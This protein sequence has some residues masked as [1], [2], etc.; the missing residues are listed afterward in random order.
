MPRPRLHAPEQVLDAVTALTAESGPAAVTIRAVAAASGVSN[1][2]IYHTFGSRTGLLAAA[3]LRAAGAFLARQRELVA[4]AGAPVEQVIAAADAPVV[5]AAE[6]PAAGALL[7]RLRPD[8]LTGADLPAEPA[9]AVAALRTELVALLVELAGAL[10]D[11]TDAG[12]V[13]TITTCVVD[14]PTAI[15]LRRDRLADATA[16]THLHA[17]VR[18]V[19]AAGPPPPK[20]HLPCN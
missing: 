7:L 10:W 12:A 4:A 5:F 18:A 17:A 19:L 15:V 9:A 8:A 1:G 2:A 16:R 6:H 20:G 14:L 3:W 11:R 13:A